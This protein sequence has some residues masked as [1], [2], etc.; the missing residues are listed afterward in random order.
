M[1]CTV[2]RSDKKAGVYLYL[3]D[4]HDWEAVPAALQQLL[5]GCQQV[6]QLNLDERD[7]LATEDIHTVKTN[8][9]EQGYHLQ[10]PPRNHAGVIHYG[11]RK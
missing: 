3:A 6:M 4:T 5:G 7:K 11:S 1:N 9:A 10:M 2:W 8:L